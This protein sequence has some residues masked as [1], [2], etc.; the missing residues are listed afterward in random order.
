MD[1]ETHFYKNR[2]QQRT[3]HFDPWV[4]EI[5]AMNH[6]AANMATAFDGLAKLIGRLFRALGRGV[7]AVRAVTPVEIEPVKIEAVKIPQP[8]QPVVVSA[9]D[10]AAA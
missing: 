7:Q 10:R 9:N 2:A 8:A 6:T 1:L 4:A 3:F 5:D